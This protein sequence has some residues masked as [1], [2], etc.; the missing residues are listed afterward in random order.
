MANSKYEKAYKEVLEIIKLFPKEEYNK[1]PK[2][3]IKFFED[4]M[5][6]NYKFE[7]NSNVGVDMESISKEANAIIVTLFQD[8]LATEE[9]NKKITEILRLNEEKAEREKRRKYNPDNLFKNNKKGT[10]TD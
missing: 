8:Y 10:P 3:K 6:K 1:I 4:N 2:S 5:D 9:Q 7:I